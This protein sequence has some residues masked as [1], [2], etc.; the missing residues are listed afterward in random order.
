MGLANYGQLKVTI[1]NWVA[2]PNDLVAQAAIPDWVALA[3]ADIR[4]DIIS[5]NVTRKTDLLLNSAAVTLPTDVQKPTD[6]FLTEAQYAGPIAIM[7]P[8][9]LSDV[10]GWHVGTG[11]PRGAALVN[12]T[13]LLAPAPDRSYI[14]T[15]IYQPLLAALVADADTNWALLNHPNVYLYGALKHGAPW[16]KEPEHLPEWAGLYDEH[17]EKMKQEKA[18]YEYGPGQIVARPAIPIG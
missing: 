10:A 7:S 13:L 18:D 5:K 9:M 8:G 12:G 1:L 14:A 2:R 15:L 11:R 16:L 17:V 4:S 3:E 6:L